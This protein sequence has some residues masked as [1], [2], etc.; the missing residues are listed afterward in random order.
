MGFVCKFDSFFLLLKCIL[1]AFCLHIRKYIHLDRNWYIFLL[2][3]IVFE[4][5]RSFL[6][7]LFAC[8]VLIQVLSTRTFICI[9]ERYYLSWKI[10]IHQLDIV[11]YSDFFFISFIKDIIWKR[12]KIHLT[13]HFTCIIIINNNYLYSL[14]FFFLQ[15]VII[16]L[17][18]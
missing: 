7:L 18:V 14:L 8:R 5:T 2:W 10:I 6:L 13:Y 4:K 15:T 11:L 9:V 12:L 3:L 1:I 17:T 16:R